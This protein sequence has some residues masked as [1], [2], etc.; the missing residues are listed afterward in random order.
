MTDTYK[1]INGEHPCTYFL[2]STVEKGNFSVNITGQDICI[3]A[4]LS[5]CYLEN[6][7][8]FSVTITN[9]RGCSVYKEENISNP[10]CVT[11]DVLLELDCVSLSIRVEATNP[12]IDYESQ[13][14]ELSGYL[15]TNTAI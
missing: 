3:S 2:C 7:T 8:L 4:D 10:S 14:L 15:V 9:S 13:T 6:S 1:N 11:P 5:D 12:V